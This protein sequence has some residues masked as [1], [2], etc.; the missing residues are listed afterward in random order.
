MS[1]ASKTFKKATNWVKNHTNEILGVMTMGASVPFT[2][3]YD[4]IQEQ[5]ELA[6]EALREQ[7]RANA[8]A[9]AIARARGVTAT[10]D[11]VGELGYVDA[12]TR[13]RRGYLGS[14]KSQKDGSNTLLAAAA[15][16]GNKKTL[17]A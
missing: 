13:R 10:A 11:N 15:T 5:K 9:E 8:E 12:D 7:E 6:K 17:G 4:N 2:T 16:Y 14:L 3:M 1:W